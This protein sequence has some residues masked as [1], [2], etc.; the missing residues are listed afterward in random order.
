MRRLRFLTGRR[1]SPTIARA[2]R[3]YNLEINCNWSLSG[4][5]AR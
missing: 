2:C 5:A 1:I 3:S 4:D